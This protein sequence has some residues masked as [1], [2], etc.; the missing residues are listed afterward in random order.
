MSASYSPNTLELVLVWGFPAALLVLGLLSLV[1]KG[2]FSIGGALT[3]ASAFALATGLVT[4][5][6]ISLIDS[7]SLAKSGNFLPTGI[8]LASLVGAA[9]F[10]LRRRNHSLVRATAATAIAA[11][12]V[13]GA[14]SVAQL[15]VY[16]R[17]DL[18]INL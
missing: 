1:R 16:C 2:P 17:F 11:L 15:F 9:Y 5:W 14:V 13:L 18:C 6:F 4:V 10:L 7:A 3:I 12:P 8:A